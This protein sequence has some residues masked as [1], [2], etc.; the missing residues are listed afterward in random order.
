VDLERNCPTLVLPKLLEP[1]DESVEYLGIAEIS[2]TVHPPM[3][4]CGAQQGI[5]GDPQAATYV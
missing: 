5:G 2:A 3:V 1:V 4:A